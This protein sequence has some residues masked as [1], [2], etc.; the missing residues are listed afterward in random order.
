MTNDANRSDIPSAVRV[1]WANEVFGIDFRSRD[2]LNNAPALMDL[3]G[4]PE[5]GHED[6]VAY[7]VTACL[8]SH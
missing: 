4:M 8:T 1:D 2:F 7:Y 5:F 3:Y 6:L